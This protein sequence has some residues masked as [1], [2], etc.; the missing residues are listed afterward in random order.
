MWLIFCR[1]W[2]DIFSYWSGTSGDPTYWLLFIY[3]GVPKSKRQR[4][5]RSL[6][7]RWGQYRGFSQCTYG[8]RWS[9][10]GRK[11]RDGWFW[12]W[13]FFSLFRWIL[14]GK[15]C[16]RSNFQEEF[17]WRIFCKR[18]GRTFISAQQAIA[19]GRVNFIVLWII[20][21]VVLF[22]VRVL[23]ENNQYFCLFIFILTFLHSFIV[24]FEA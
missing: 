6:F 20:F 22:L 3:W 7:W 15:V 21:R 14:W 13:V 24:V 1:E 2:G 11:S 17:Y 4:N 5:I 19:Q 18:V 9:W 23:L 16:N 8:R 12:I 10:G